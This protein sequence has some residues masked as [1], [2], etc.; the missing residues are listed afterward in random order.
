M[1]RALTSQPHVETRPVNGNV[2][3]SFF[4]VDCDGPLGEITLATLH[5][6]RP[7]SD[8]SHARKYPWG[9]HGGLCSDCT[10][11]RGFPET[12]FL[13][14]PIRPGQNYAQAL[15]VHLAEVTSVVDAL[16]TIPQD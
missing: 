11:A 5:R 8:W 1:A 3:H 12:D 16:A 6:C 7:N 14:V 9:E 4:C 10:A 2:V 13:L 15:R